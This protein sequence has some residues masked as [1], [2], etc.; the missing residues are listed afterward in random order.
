M[1]LMDLK[2]VYHK[3]INAWYLIYQLT[4][5]TTCAHILHSGYLVETD[6]S[7]ALGLMATD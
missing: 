1:H 7:E 2:S 3:P 5:C 6:Y 4:E